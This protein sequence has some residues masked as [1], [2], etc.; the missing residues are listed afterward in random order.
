MCMHIRMYVNVVANSVMLYLRRDLC[1][2]IFKI[3]NI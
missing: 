3:N 2:I 1:N